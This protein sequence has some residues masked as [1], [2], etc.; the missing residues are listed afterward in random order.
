MCLFVRCED[1]SEL[2]PDQKAILKKLCAKPSEPLT[3]LTAVARRD[4]GYRHNNALFLSM[5]LCLI[6]TDAILKI[7]VG[8]LVKLKDEIAEELVDLFRAHGFAPNPEVL[9]KSFFSKQE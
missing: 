7:P 8:T 4:W 5:W 2:C 6:A 3:T 1:L 9:L